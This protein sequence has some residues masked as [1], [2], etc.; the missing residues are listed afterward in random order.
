[1]KVQTKRI[2]DALLVS[3]TG[4][5]DHHSA[6]YVREKIDNIIEDPSVTYIVF[7]LR[8]MTFMDSSGIGVFLGRYRILHKRHGNILVADVNSSVDKILK[9]SGLYRIL[10]KFDSVEEALS[11]VQGGVR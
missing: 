4:E 5:L 10:K 2:R 8:G 6:E 1:M 3:I 11:D 7:N 9:L